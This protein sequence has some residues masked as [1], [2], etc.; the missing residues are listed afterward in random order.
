[1]QIKPFGNNILV[2]PAV[3]KQ[4]LVADEGMLCEYGEVIAIGDRVRT[5]KVGDKIGYS[6]FG[7][8]KLVIEEEKFYL[9]PEDQRFLLGFLVE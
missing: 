7:I 6:V 8:E 5:V 3:K 4:V 2:R 9:L 1:M